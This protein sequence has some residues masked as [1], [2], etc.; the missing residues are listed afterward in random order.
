MAPLYIL[1]YHEVAING[2]ANYSIFKD[3]F[4]PVYYR[5]ILTNFKWV[6]LKKVPTTF[7]RI[8]DIGFD[9]EKMVRPF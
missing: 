6:N 9:Q 2:S 4:P 1:F 7:K 3:Q 8:L 5:A